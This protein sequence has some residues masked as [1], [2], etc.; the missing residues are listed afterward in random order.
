M[1]T[2]YFL[3]ISYFFYSSRLYFKFAYEGLTI[4]LH[5]HGVTTLRV[6][7]DIDVEGNNVASINGFLIDFFACFVS[8]AYQIGI[9]EWV[10]VDRQ[11]Q[12]IVFT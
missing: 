4:I 7:G 11:L 8:N 1:S 3:L 6:G 10:E 2:R 5:S 12:I 9:V